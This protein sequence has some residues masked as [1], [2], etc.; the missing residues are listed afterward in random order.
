MGVLVGL[1]VDSEVEDLRGLVWEFWFLGMSFLAGSELESLSSDVLSPTFVS[2]SDFSLSTVFSSLPALILSGLASPSSSL[3]YELPIATIALVS[4]S[5]GAKYCTSALRAD[6][7]NKSASL[8]QHTKSIFSP[9]GGA[10]SS[11]RKRDKVLEEL[12]LEMKV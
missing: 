6:I 3:A 10:K 9:F 4:S 1:G 5:R 12:L 11:T 2:I 8:G 7:G